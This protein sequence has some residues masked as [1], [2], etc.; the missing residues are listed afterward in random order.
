MWE[1]FK[2]I[3][4]GRIS[5]RR[6]SLLATSVLMAIFLATGVIAPTV[7]AADA[8]RSGNTVTYEGKTYQPIDKTATP[9]QVP[10]GLPTTEG[11]V[12]F[13][14]NG[15]KAYYLLTNGPAASSTTATYTVYDMPTM[16][17]YGNHSPPTNIAIVSSPVSAATQQ[18]SGTTCD[19][20]QTAGIGWILCPVV[21]FL[22]KSMDYI[23][24][25]I[26]DFL[27][28]RTITTDT[29]GSLYRMWAIIRDIANLCFVG[30]FLVII[31][32]QI[33][34][35]GYSN[36]NL[37]KMLPRLIIGA[38][39][40]NTSFWISGLAV[41]ASNILGVSIHD[42]FMTVMQNLNTNGNYD[43]VTVPD[44]QSITIIALSG[45]AATAG[46]TI[47]VLANTV[48][49]ALA[50][51][52]PA[53]VGV[54]LAALVAF[55]VLAARQAL[56]VCLVIISPLAFAAML[57][58]NTEK[59]FDKWRGALT[60]LLLLFPIF[61]VIFSG[62][63][64]AGMAIVQS[65]GGNLVTIILGMTVQVA[66]IVITPLLVKFSGGLIGRI[67]GMVNN[68]NKGLLDR[69][70]NW[71]KGFAAERR[72]RAIAGRMMPDGTTQLK[73][74]H[75]P[76]AYLDARRRAR[77]G[78][79]KA[80]ESGAEARF[81]GTRQGHDVEALN[82][83]YGNVKARN[84]NRFAASPRGNRLEIEA[85]HIA[86][87][88][89]NIET[90]MMSDP[91][92][93]Y[94]LRT[95]QRDA[96]TAK[97]N[98]DSKYL[99]DE[100]GQKAEYRSRMANVRKTLAESKFE[101]TSMGA[102]VDMAKR[103]VERRKHTAEA[104]HEQSWH[105]RNQTDAGSQEREMKLRIST[106]G[107]SAAKAKVDAIYNE[108]KLDNTSG[109]TTTMLNSVK[110]QLGKEA[111]QVALETNLTAKRSA[112]ADSELKSKIN[113]E[114]L[115]DGV[116]YQLD[117]HG[118]K[119]LDASGSPIVA[120]RI[121]VD[122]KTLQDYATGI[123]KRELMLA[124][125]VAEDRAD[126][127]KQAQAAS[128]LIAHFKL[129]SNAVQKLAIGGEGSDPGERYVTIK[130]DSGNEFTF[131]A[132]DEYVKEAAISKQFKAGSYGQ[133]MAILKETGENI[134]I[135]DASGNI[136]GHRTGYNYHHRATA[137]SDAIASGIA[138]LA[139]FINDVTYNEILKGNFNG[140]D[141]MRMHALRQ[142][143]EGRIKAS[144]LTGANQDA[145][146]ILYDLGR[147]KES[148]DPSKRAEYDRYKTMLTEFFGDSYGTDSAMYK[149]A[150]T[151]FDSVFDEKWRGLL[152]TTKGIM[153]NSNLNSNTAD[154]AKKVM[155]DILVE[156]GVTFRER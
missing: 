42:V 30:V 80:Y 52:I 91:E 31:Y 141:S 1:S 26:A 55:V 37:K 127:G 122:G 47:F 155:R 104:H 101:E 154:E 130:D 50:L 40:V 152:S 115:T 84:E 73:R 45:S 75:V 43:S 59:Y 148:A 28:V 82:K 4:H 23:Y 146:S 107:A 89:Q 142:V 9:S 138:G 39:L 11:Y 65:A 48:T 100:Q 123:G 21:N 60:T 134:A 24:K 126:W 16:G 20:T 22:A 90:Q 62:A 36:Y 88:K 114:L 110:D 19:S 2:I 57:L 72:N 98:A 111:F 76:T 136:V 95:R 119:V 96:E 151:N 125:S 116:T 139:P 106:D 34:G 18:N 124:N 70:K 81:S 29:S 79:R 77:E 109:L 143:F 102:R 145:L 46:L 97:L 3:S 113:K 51:L 17:S 74:R 64:L 33:S 92:H 69:T 150:T 68:P 8:V 128:E 38:I 15:K 133:K 137:Q 6:L 135:K 14:T 35:L 117:M 144:N 12:S 13:D 147:L 63:Q 54:L 67:A 149:A 32:S 93:G 78:R 49:G 99:Q 58:P 86:V 5:L 105:F 87:D 83:H 66:P 121:T 103:E 153:E 132:A 61:S 118:N 71:S 44:W 27:V 112:T 131:D 53:L 25:V 108:L 129:D 94:K 7:L 85:R 56:I 10:A 140:D 120:S 156:E 41:D